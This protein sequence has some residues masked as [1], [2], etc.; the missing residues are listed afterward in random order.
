VTKISSDQLPH[1]L[2]LSGETLLLV[3]A[4]GQN[5][6]VQSSERL[7]NFGLVLPD[8]M[9]LFHGNQLDALNL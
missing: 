3:E 1:E 2:L 5:L 7:E 4:G 9:L 6:L 8:V